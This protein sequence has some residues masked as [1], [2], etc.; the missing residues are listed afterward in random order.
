MKKRA[1]ELESMKRLQGALPVPIDPNLDN[2]TFSSRIVRVMASVNY[3]DDAH[4]CIAG[5]RL[6]EFR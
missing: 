5:M 1:A 2:V 6:D 3:P 4:F